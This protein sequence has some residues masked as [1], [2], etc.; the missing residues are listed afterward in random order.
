MRYFDKTQARLLH[1]LLDDGELCDAEMGLCVFR[2]VASATHFFVLQR[3]GE[4]L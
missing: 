3:E 4:R 2:C 1:S